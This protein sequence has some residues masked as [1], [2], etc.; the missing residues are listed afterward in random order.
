MFGSGR[1]RTLGTG[2][3]IAVA[4]L[5]AA[6]HASATP[7]RAGHDLATPGGISVTTKATIELPGVGGHGDEVIADPAAHSVYIS[8]TPDNNVVILNTDTNRIRAVVGGVAEA[9][10]IDYSPD[11][12]FVAAAKSN[13]IAVIS[14]AT[15][16]LVATVPSG[17][18]SPDAV[19][20]Y[21]GKNSVFVGNVDS[22]NLVELSATAPFGIKGT[23]AMPA[24]GASGEDLGT[25]VPTT[26][27]IYQSLDN[28][29]VVIDPRTRTIK[30]VFTL[31]LPATESSKAIFYDRRQNL[32]WVGTTASKVLAVDPTT[33]AVAETVK[34]AGGMD[35]VSGDESRQL[36]FLG[37]K[38]GVMGIVDLQAKKNVADV[39]TE[40]VFHTLAYLPETGNVYAYW[41]KSNKVVV[42]H[43]VSRTPLGGVATGG[44]S[45]AA[46]RRDEPLLYGGAAA[47]A[48]AAA[49]AFGLLASRR[50]YRPSEH[51]TS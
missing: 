13:A 27:R 10:G 4:V 6:P 37:E 23:L 35:Q 2:M 17:G 14:K 51:H 5:A 30:T 21:P 7:P 49:L 38:T 25:Y 22:N 9:N 43:V 32:L 34:T 18:T 42:Y 8:Q 1:A 33:G 29:I 16:R 19:Y 12:V 11:Y 39:P 3:A 46:G 26:D 36:L 44:G 41:N 45:T 40:P 48:A 50:R 31:P 15:W 24:K 47:L 20:Y 28:R